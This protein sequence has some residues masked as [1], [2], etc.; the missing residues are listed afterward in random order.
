MKFQA[1]IGLTETEI[2]FLVKSNEVDYAGLL[3]SMQDMLHY[4][5]DELTFLLTI[6][7]NSK[8]A[9]DT[10]LLRSDLLKTLSTSEVTDGMLKVLLGTDLHYADKVAAMTT[11]KVRHMID[12]EA[13]G[14]FWVELQL[15]T[16]EKLMFILQRAIDEYFKG[17]GKLMRMVR[18]RV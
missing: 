8:V 4:V 14:N 9:K 3:Q 13:I 12:P 1:G 15:Y 10:G 7:I 11:A 16:K 5:L 6:W 18:G 2:V 17:T